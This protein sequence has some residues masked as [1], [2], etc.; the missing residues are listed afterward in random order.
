M[1]KL[2]E[3]IYSDIKSGYEE[4]P[5]DRLNKSY[6]NDLIKKLVDIS[7]KLEASQTDIESSS[8]EFQN[9]MYE[10]LP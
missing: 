10:K 6:I 1:S 7:I 3:K 2:S 5:D 8:I 9:Y 4:L